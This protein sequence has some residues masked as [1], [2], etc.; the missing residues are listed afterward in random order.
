MLYT[1]KLSLKIKASVKFGNFMSLSG[2]LTSDFSRCDYR[3]AQMKHTVVYDYIIVAIKNSQHV[4]FQGRHDHR[5][6]TACTNET[7]INK[8]VRAHGRLWSPSLFVKPTPPKAKEFSSVVGF[9][10][11]E[12]LI[13]EIE[14]HLAVYDCSL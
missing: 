10:D 2:P 3:A 7:H 9:K 13:S 11:F 14:R 12:I 6:T 5:L 1:N 4:P 8:S